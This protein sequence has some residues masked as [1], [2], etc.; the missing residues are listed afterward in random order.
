MQFV[1]YATRNLLQSSKSLDTWENTTL[2]LNLVVLSVKDNMTHTMVR[3]NTKK[4]TGSYV[5]HVEIVEVNYSSNFSLQH[6]STFTTRMNRLSVKKC[7]HI[8][9]SKSFMVAHLATYR[10]KIKF[11]C[12]QCGHKTNTKSNL[13]QH[14]WGKHGEGWVS[15]CGQH[16]SWH[17]RLYWHYEKCK[18]CEDI[19]NRKDSK[20]QKLHRVLKSK[21]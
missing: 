17:M 19:Q 1:Q 10:T 15:E 9:T 2:A 14:I 13:D 6:M 8:Y 11:I 3:S 12:D 18:Q 4:V 7:P 21:S 20:V 16:F 5:F